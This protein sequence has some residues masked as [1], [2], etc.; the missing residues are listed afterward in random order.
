MAEQEQQSEKEKLGI[1]MRFFAALR[2][3]RRIFKW[4]GLGL[5]SILLIAGFIF[6]APWKIITLL[7]VILLACAVLPKPYRKWFWVSIGIVVVA[8]IVWVFLPDRGEWKPYAFDEELAAIEAA[9]AIPDSENAATIYNRL[10]ENYDKGDFE[11]NLSG[12]NTYYLTKS[13]P[14]SS[15]DYPELAEWLKG[16]QNTIATLVAAAQKDKCQFPIVADLVNF[17]PRMERLAAM[18]R[19]VYLL[20]RAA[21]NDLGEGRIDAGLEKYFCVLQMADHIYQQSTLIELLAGIAMEALA[22]KQFN[23]FIVTGDVAEEHLT[24]VEKAL[25]GIKHDWSTDWPR[26]LECEKLLFKNMFGMIFYEINP[27]GK[28]RLTRNQAAAMGPQLEQMG[29]KLNY[30]KIKLMKA[31]VI[32]SWF[33]MPTTPQK[34]SDII[35]TAYKKYYAMAS[36]D[37]DW[38]KGPT[39]PSLKFRLNYRYLVKH[40][41]SFLEQTYYSIHDTYLRVIT[42]KRGSRLIVALRRYKNKSGQWP[43]TLDDI[44]SLVP[45]ETLVDAINGNSFVYNLTEENFTLYSKGK[46]SIDEGGKRDKWDEEKTGSD[47]WL[48]W[49]Q[50][51]RKA[52][53]EK[54]DAE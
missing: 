8:L 46:N 20:I 15:K 22:T 36:P 40:I 31:K 13:E 38:Q 35:D 28:V 10:L 7:V 45:G 32:L 44:R 23:R 49:P 30:W 34:A 6:Q 54:A 37:F 12:P 11:P 5:L 14:W 41:A 51:S 48:I 53:E 50:R 33:Y 19:W 43:E 1:F 39:N 47:D 26:I 25:A 3:T 42:D 16:Q 4:I 24:V 2:M 18:R 21:N 27:E 9:R 29:I 17:S 52:K